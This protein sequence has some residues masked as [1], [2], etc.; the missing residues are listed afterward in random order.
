M[1]D[2]EIVNE[3]GHFTYRIENAN[4]KCKL[5]INHG[6]N[7]DLTIEYT[8]AGKRA[9]NPISIFNW[10]AQADTG[11][12][13]SYAIADRFCCRGD[14]FKIQRK[15]KKLLSHLNALTRNIISEN[16]H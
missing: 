7:Y 9:E 16:L 6:L 13:L 12:P 8:S 11:F 14:C 3:L 4:I 1:K 2:S 10:V 5:A 15:W